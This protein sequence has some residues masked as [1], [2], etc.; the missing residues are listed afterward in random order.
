MKRVAGMR[1]EGSGTSEYV[2]C[3]CPLLHSP[4]CRFLK[5]SPRAKPFITLF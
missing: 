3:C 1:K 4:K 2:L 5:G